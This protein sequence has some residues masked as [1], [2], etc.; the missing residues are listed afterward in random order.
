MTANGIVRIVQRLYERK[1]NLKSLQIH[2]ICNIT[3][4]HLDILKLLLLG[5]NHQQVLPPTNDRYWHSFTFINHDDRPIDVD[6]CPKCK[7]VRMVFDCTRENCRLVSSGY[8]I[9]LIFF[10]SNIWSEISNN[11]VRD[12]LSILFSSIFSLVNYHPSQT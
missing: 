8:H 5:S 7:H 6:I 9:I 1:G 11:V 4:D 10:L 2:G 12:L 3:K